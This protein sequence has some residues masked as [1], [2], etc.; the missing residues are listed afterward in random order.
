MNNIEDKFNSILSRDV[1]QRVDDTH[2]VNLYLG[3]DDMSRWTLLLVCNDRPKPLFSSKVISVRLGKRNDSRWTLSF[4]LIDDDYKDLFILFCNDIIETS[5][6]LND[7]GSSYVISRYEEW[8]NLLANT[9]NG[10]LSDLQIKGLLGEMFFIENE[11]ISLYGIDESVS[12]W[13]G[14]ELGHQ[15][16]VIDNTWYEVKT[17][18]SG[19]EEVRISSVEQLDCKEEGKLIV[20]F[21]DKTSITN[22]KALNLNLIYYRLLSQMVNEDTKISFNKKLFKLGYY[23]RPEYEDEDYTFMINGVSHYCVNESFPCL[24]RNSIPSNILR[25]DYTISLPAIKSYRED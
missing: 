11:L 4:S 23:P 8:K 9:K 7:K 6:P 5:R 24:R 12:S 18:S 25:A 2:P 19:M 22:K 14:P 20:V 17:V 10:L 15:D 21:V 13:M 16:F 3:I 1:Y